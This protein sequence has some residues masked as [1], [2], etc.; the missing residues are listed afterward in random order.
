MCDDDGPFMAKR[1]YDKLFEA[2]TIDLDA[3][4][5]ALDHA[6]AALRDGGASPERWAMFIHMGA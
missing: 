5:Y 3:I 4:P 6:V 1:F 2:N